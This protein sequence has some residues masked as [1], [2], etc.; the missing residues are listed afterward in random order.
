MK[1][2]YSGGAIDMNIFLLTLFGIVIFLII[3][4]IDSVKDN[5]IERYIQSKKVL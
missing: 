3:V 2:L 5:K 4:I 1:Q